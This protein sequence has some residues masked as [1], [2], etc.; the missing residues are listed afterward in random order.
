MTENQRF[1]LIWGSVA[2]AIGSFMMIFNEA[3][4]VLLASFFT[5]AFAVLLGTALGIVGAAI[6]E[7]IRRFAL[8]SGFFTTGGMTSIIKTKLFWMIGPQFIGMFIGMG[9][10]IGFVMR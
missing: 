8:P 10:G 4:R 5:K 6:G 2:F 1:A 9:L 3:P 7:S